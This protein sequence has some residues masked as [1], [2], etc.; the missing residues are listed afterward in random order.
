MSYGSARRQV[1]PLEVKYN[2]ARAFHMLGMC[3]HAQEL[4][5]ELLKEAAFEESASD[6]VQRARLNLAQILK[7][8][9]VNYGMRI[10]GISV[11]NDPL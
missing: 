8:S 11:A 7:G 10:R 4:Y 1:C 9:G 5:E 2:M 3:G 6:I